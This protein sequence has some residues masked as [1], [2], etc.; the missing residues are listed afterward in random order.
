VNFLQTPGKRKSLSWSF[1]ISKI[2][3]SLWKS[4][5]YSNNLGESLFLDLITAYNTQN[6]PIRKYKPFICFSINNE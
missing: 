5:S 3:F 1:E 6:S 2:N 4:M